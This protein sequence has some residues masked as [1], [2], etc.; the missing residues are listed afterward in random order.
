MGNA[1]TLFYRK[2][3]AKAFAFANGIG[4][5][6]THSFLLEAQCAY[7]DVMKDVFFLYI[8]KLVLML[9]AKIE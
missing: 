8:C 5:K 7:G 9:Y 1:L 6:N 2:Y 4:A 3:S